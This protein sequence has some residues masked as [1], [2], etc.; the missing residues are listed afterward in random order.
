MTPR[1]AA[2]GLSLALVAL[3]P[4]GRAHLR[5]PT[6]K[7]ERWIELRLGEQPMRLGYRIG[8]GEVLAA[9]ARKAA[10]LDGDHQIS[11]A[12]GNAA[13]DARS[14]ELVRSLSVCTG[15]TLADVRCRALT[16]RDIERVEAE[17]WV[18]GQNGHLH[19]SWTF[20]LAEQATEVGALRLEDRYDVPGVEITDVLIDPPAHS[21]L[22]RAGDGRRS[23]G[24]ALSFNW[25]E[26]LREPGPRAVV[27][28]WAPPRSRARASLVIGAL[29]VLVPIVAWLAHRRRRRSP[30]N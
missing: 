27:A 25:I 18:P 5:F 12:E 17:G 4:G 16:A 20:R 14:A 24:V 3:A 2:L 28:V 19:F 29:M 7:A 9:E 8:L 26:R 30:R 10:D 11:A 13:L 22:S 15:R 21:P 23:H 1:G 6:V